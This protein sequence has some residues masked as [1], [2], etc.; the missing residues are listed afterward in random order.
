[1][2]EKNILGSHSTRNVSIFFNGTLVPTK[3]N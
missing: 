3:M 2:V 1:M